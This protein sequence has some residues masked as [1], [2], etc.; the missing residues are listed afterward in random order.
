MLSTI[1]FAELYFRIAKIAR[2]FPISLCFVPHLSPKMLSCV[3]FAIHILLH[4]ARVTAQSVSVSL[5]P[6]VDPVSLAQALNIS[7]DC[8]DAL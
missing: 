4:A 5:Y 2:D 3:L 6:T 8:L 1:F 7:N